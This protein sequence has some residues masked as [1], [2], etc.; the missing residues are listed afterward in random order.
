[1]V[2]SIF[3]EYLQEAHIDF[4]TQSIMSLPETVRHRTKLTISIIAINDQEKQT[5]LY[6]QNYSI[7]LIII[8]RG[9]YLHFFP[10]IFSRDDHRGW[11]HTPTVMILEEYFECPYRYCAELELL[12]LIQQIH[13]VSKCY[14]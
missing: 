14:Q 2:L 5:L 8:L 1:L 3:C 13:S 10:A 6:V 12:L 7:T 9:R 11:K 4:E